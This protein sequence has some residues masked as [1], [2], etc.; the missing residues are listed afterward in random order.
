MSTVGTTWKNRGRSNANIRYGA[1]TPL[2]KWNLV[3][4]MKVCGHSGAL[5]LSKGFLTT[6]LVLL[7][8]WSH[9]RSGVVPVGLKSLSRLPSSCRVVCCLT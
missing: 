8:Q 5:V 6:H 4:Y 1:E 7:W 2:K 3:S 9:R